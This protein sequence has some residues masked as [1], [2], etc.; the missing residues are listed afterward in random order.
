MATNEFLKKIKEKAERNALNRRDLRFKSTIALLKGK[1]LLDTNLPIRAA[2]GLRVE[3]KDV[4]WAGR[5]VEPRIL[6]VLPAAMMHYRKNFLGMEHLPEGLK[7]VLKAIQANAVRG[8]SFEGIAFERMS[9][10]ANSRLKDRRTKPANEKKVPKYLMLHVKHLNK[11]V[12]L[13]ESGRFKDQTSAI[14]AA[15]DQL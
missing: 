15:I 5:N 8:P 11:L 7:K 2:P 10:W 3:I 9:H 13:V 1:G 4:L 12:R 14:E 6:E